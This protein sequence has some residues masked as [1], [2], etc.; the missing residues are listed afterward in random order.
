MMRGSKNSVDRKCNPE[1]DT[2]R[3]I[4]YTYAVFARFLKYLTH[5]VALWLSNVHSDEQ[6]SQPPLEVVIMKFPLLNKVCAFDKDKY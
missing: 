2:G 3:S 6:T 1:S 5:H 4:K